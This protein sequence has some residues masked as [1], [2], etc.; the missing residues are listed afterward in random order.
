MPGPSSSMYKIAIMQLG[1]ASNENVTSSVAQYLCNYHGFRQ[2]RFEKHYQTQSLLNTTN[3]FRSQ[4][5]KQVH[6][7]S[8]LFL[9]RDQLDHIRHQ[10]NLILL[11]KRDPNQ[12][13]TSSS[14]DMYDVIPTDRWLPDEDHISY[15]ENNGSMNHLYRQ[16]NSLITMGQ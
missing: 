8:N 6:V 13:Q 2:I 7:Y 15:L 5:L 3:D 4:D 10:Y 14:Q 12:L 1:N 9:F 16:V 11:L